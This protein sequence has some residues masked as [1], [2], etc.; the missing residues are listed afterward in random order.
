M[1]GLGI[2]TLNEGKREE[3]LYLT[4]GSNVI[5]VYVFSV[6]PLSKQTEL[7]CRVKYS[8]KTFGTT[9]LAQL[10]RHTCFCWVFS[11]Q[12]AQNVLL[13]FFTTLIIFFCDI[14]IWNWKCLH[15]LIPYYHTTPANP[16]YCNTFIHRPSLGPHYRSIHKQYKSFSSLSFNCSLSSTPCRLSWIH[17]ILSPIALSLL[18][19]FKV[20]PRLSQSYF[21]AFTSLVRSCFWEVYTCR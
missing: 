6:P 14:Y 21:K 5:S 13:S 4:M 2:W 19:N 9:V 7:Q 3:G 20:L 16:L 1:S 15:H 18:H 11:R 10:N 12:N 8:S 17:S